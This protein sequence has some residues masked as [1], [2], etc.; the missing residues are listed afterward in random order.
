MNN[1]VEALAGSRR[2]EIACD[3]IVFRFA[4]LKR[5][6]ATRISFAKPLPADRVRNIKQVKL[7]GRTG[8]L[9]QRPHPAADTDS[10]CLEIQDDVQ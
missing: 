5:V 8:L 2:D 9:D 1:D 6:R 4:Y 7:V 10:V 3:Q